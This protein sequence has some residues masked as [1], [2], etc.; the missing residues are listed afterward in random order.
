MKLECAEI[1]NND[2]IG[3]DLYKL[4][5]F[6]PSISKSACAGQFVNIKCCAPEQLDPLLRRPFS[7]YDTDKKF[8][9]V[10]ILYLVRGR[11][12]RFLSR[13]ARGDIIDLCGPLGKPLKPTG[14]KIL[15]IAGGIGFAPL[16]FLAQSCIN[17]KK[18]V[19]IMAGFKDQRYMLVEKDIMRMNIDY[20]IFCEKERWANQGTVTDGLEN[21]SKFKEYEIY[22]CGPQG[23]LKQLQNKLA[24]VNNKIMALLEERM[25]CGIGVCAGCAVK[26]KGNGNSFS[27]KKVCS[28]G[29]AFNLMEV[30]FE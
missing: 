18:E 23:L 15:L 29:P 27:Y 5:F 21:I 9:V 3:E 12:T 19:Y 13:L 20:M 25:A 11:G 2:R 22:C 6:S 8:N 24:G 28:D 30:V 10:T 16:H 17:Q 7:I 4:E 14:N 26:I 1:V